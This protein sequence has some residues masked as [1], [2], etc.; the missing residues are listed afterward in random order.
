[1]IFL[2]RTNIYNQM[3]DIKPINSAVVGGIFK[4]R[5]SNSHKYTFGHTLIVAGKRGMAGA[6]I[7]SAKACLR[8]GAGLVTLVSPQCNR[9]ILQTAVPEAIFACNSDLLTENILQKRYNSIAIGPGIATDNKTAT[10]FRSLLTIAASPLVLDADALNI[11]SAD[12]SLLDILPE[13]CIITPHQK[14][15]ERLA[16]NFSAAE[17]A[18]KH[19]IVVV[20]K[21]SKTHIYAPNGEIYINETEN[22]GLATAGS[23]DVLTGIIAALL[24]QAYEPLQAAILGVYL[25]SQAG[26]L[27]LVAQSEQSMLASDIIENLGK[28]FKSL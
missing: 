6:A 23:G 18:I 7:L 19:K 27:A 14:E 3:I 12:K 16:G 15:F 5:P 26:Q 2:Q 4:P 13:N 21:G 25:H 20:L 28:A 9:I 24:A 10:V 1:M 11:I 22:S 17:M 8:S